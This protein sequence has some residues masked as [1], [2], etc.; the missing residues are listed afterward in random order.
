MVSARFGA[1]KTV[2]VE[3]AV[4]ATLALAVPAE[5]RGWKGD[6]TSSDTEVAIATTV[7]SSS[8]WLLLFLQVPFS[9]GTAVGTKVAVICGVIVAVAVVVVVVV[10]GNNRSR[11]SLST[12]AEKGG[13]DNDAGMLIA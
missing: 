11:S 7:T 9:I 5:W 12:V 4:V 1:A 3:E 2:L 13:G 10:D 8:P 6:E